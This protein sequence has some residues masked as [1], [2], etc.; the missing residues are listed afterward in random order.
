MTSCASPPTTIPSRV[1][2]RN[3][4]SGTGSLGPTPEN[5]HKRL[6]SQHP[7]LP[8]HPPPPLRPKPNKPSRIKPIR[9]GSGSNS[10]VNK[11]TSFYDNVT[12]SSNTSVDGEAV[13]AY[14]EQL[15]KNSRKSIEIADTVSETSVHVG[16]DNSLSSSEKHELES[17]RES[18]RSSTKA[19]AGSVAAPGSITSS[20]LTN[21]SCNTDEES[22]TESIPSE[23][24]TFSTLSSHR[25]SQS[26]PMNPVTGFCE[27]STP[28]PLVP[29][30]VPM[31][32]HRK[33]KR[34]TL[35]KVSLTIRII[36]ISNSS[37]TPIK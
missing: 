14:A 29:P 2:H 23:E 4:D 5:T 26:S 35:V 28:S 34:D 22:N 18:S 31:R 13:S 15:R 20:R 9:S 11:R 36:L 7:A 3:E 30:P 27:G 19:T 12:Q 33:T 6:L 16:D 1:S 10:K 25:S 8:S 21:G 17:S 32:S 24:R 37:F